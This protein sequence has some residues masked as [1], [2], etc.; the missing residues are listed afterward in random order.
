MK[1]QLKKLG[2]LLCCTAFLWSCT[3]VEDVYED[4]IGED[5]TEIVTDQSKNKIL[6]YKITNPGEKDAI[7]SAINHDAKTIT[8]YLPA[9]YELEFMEVAIELPEGTTITP[10]TDELVPVFADQPF[11]YTITAAD[12]TTATYTLNIAIQYPDMVLDEISTETKTLSL[13][14]IVTITGRNFLASGSVT[15][16]YLTDEDGNKV[17]SG[18]SMDEANADSKRL[19]FSAVTEATIEAYEELSADKEKKY[20]LQL[21]SYGIVKRMTYPVTLQ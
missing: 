7:Y 20:W 1:K 4:R 6:T 18:Y 16:L 5:V 8:T 12:G 13:F 11:K 17:W 21:E 3:K 2:C 10:S 15:R 19:K 14:S 9:Y